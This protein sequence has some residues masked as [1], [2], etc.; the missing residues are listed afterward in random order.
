[1]AIR[2]EPMD[3]LMENTTMEKVFVNDV[4]RLYEITPNAGYVLHDNRL[5]YYDSY[6]DEDNPIGEPV[7]GFQTGTA[8][9]TIAQFEA[10]TFE[11]YVVLDTDVPENSYICGDTTEP[12]H[13]TM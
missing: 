7:L 13:E 10:N 3:T 2:R 4:H 5:D 1:M 12:D 11:F 8:S 6:N 9:C